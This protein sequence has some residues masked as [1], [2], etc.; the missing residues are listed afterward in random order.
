MPKY[1]IVYKG[2]A[3]DPADMPEEQRNEI[4]AA[5]GVWMERV[6]SGLADV[7]TPLMAVASVVDDG[8][9]GTP[10]SLSGYSV[11]EAAGLDELQSHVK[12]HPFLSEGQGNFAIDV[13]EMLSIPM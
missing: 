3:T 11:V 10:V 13:Y 5:W 1:M 9:A 2:D 8:S 12:D 7:G 4:M 6:G